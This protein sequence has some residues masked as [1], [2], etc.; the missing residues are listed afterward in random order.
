[1]HDGQTEVECLLHH[2]TEAVISRWAENTVRN[3][4]EGSE[5]ISAHP[6]T[7]HKIPLRMPSPEFVNNVKSIEKRLHILIKA[8][9]LRHRTIIKNDHFSHRSSSWSQ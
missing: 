4:I 8:T 3:P 1:M 2:D 5:M 9:L 6:L 7:V